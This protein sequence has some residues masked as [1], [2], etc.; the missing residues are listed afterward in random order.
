MTTNTERPSPN[1]LAEILEPIR[2]RVLR[3]RLEQGERDG[4]MLVD[5]QERIDDKPPGL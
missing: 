3:E 2:Q 4:C 1:P 5:W